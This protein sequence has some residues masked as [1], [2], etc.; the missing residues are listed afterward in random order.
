MAVGK[1]GSSG[2]QSQA[3]SQQQSG[4]MSNAGITGGFQSGLTQAVAPQGYED[5]WRKMLAGGGSTPGQT[6]AASFFTGNG[7]IKNSLLNPTS[8]GWYGANDRNA[9]LQTLANP[10]G[11]AAAY[12]PA[13]VV[14]AAGDITANTAASFMSPYSQGYTQNVV[15][16][17]TNDM[18]SALGKG[19]N[20]ISAQ[21][22]GQYGNGRSGVAM[23]Q[24]VGDFTR[25][26]GTTTAGLRDQGF[27]RALGAGQFDSGQNL[28]A[29]TQNV[30]NNM[31]TDQFNSTLKNNR[32][33][34]GA[35]T[36]IGAN[37]AQMGNTATA[38]NIGTN[39][40]NSAANIGGQGFAQQLA[41]L[42]A[43]NPLIGQASQSANKGGQVGATDTA[44]ASNSTGSGKNSSKGGGISA[45]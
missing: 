26:L 29:Q 45:G 36:M 42:Q 37:Q 4:N 7:D 30:S 14:G 22:G 33:Q 23:G 18:T 28:A 5:A 1:G 25:A 16:A 43:G 6:G 17:T 35:N 13:P 41:A 10:G 11:F 40:A 15:D 9:N 39:A 24:A 19:L 38:A 32:D 31:A 44:G 20:E 27:G 3:Q 34:F 12:G 2:S 21:Y 8:N